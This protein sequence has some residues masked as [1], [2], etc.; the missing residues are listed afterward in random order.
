MNTQLT[1]LLCLLR[2]LIRV[3]IIIE[4]DADKWLAHVATGKNQTGWIP[5]LALRVG[6][7]HTWWWKK[8]CYNQCT[9]INCGHTFITHETFVRSVM[10]AGKV[11]DAHVHA[12]GK[13]SSLP[14]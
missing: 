9:N 10:V 13:Q 2:N 7:A 12:K 5:W 14:F 6:T 11:I 8:E 4:V 1:E 3:G